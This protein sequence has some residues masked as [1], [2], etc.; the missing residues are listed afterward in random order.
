VALFGVTLLGVVLARRR[1]L[2]V[3]DGSAVT[4]SRLDPY[5][6][7]YLNGGGSLVAA[8][9]FSSLLR[10]GFAANTARRGRWVRLAATRA[11]PP[12]RLVV[13]VRAPGLGECWL[14]VPLG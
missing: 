11:G 4:P 3:P 10:G 9:A 5:E 14:T 6:A 13:T 8:T 12:R 1:V 2:A 7:A